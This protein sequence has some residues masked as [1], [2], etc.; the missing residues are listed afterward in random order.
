MARRFYQV[1]TLFEPDLNSEVNM[2]N[3]LISVYIP[4]HNRSEML[5]RAVFSV[6]KQTYKNVEIIICDDGS[7]DNTEQVV[8]ALQE[9]YKTFAI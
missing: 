4:T 7:S 9:K 2:N 5:K 8:I 1:L 3:A 6:I